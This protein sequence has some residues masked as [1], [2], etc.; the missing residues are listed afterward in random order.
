MGKL[1]DACARELM[2]TAPVIMRT[3]RSEMRHGHDTDL[4]I[5]QFRTLGFIQRQPEASLTDLADHLGIT[6]PSVSKLVDGLVKQELISRQQGRSDRRK[7]T[8]ELTP[9]GTSI[10]NS[11]QA[12][13]HAN[14][15]RTLSGLSSE[16]LKIIHQAMEVLHGLF[17][18]Q[19]KRGPRK[20]S[21]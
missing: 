17:T 1:I 19:S 16:K 3:I 10:I 14:L 12:H 6:P 5:P 15:A 2:E 11:A 13:A 18:P 7:L 4:S 21:K 8:L 9:N 20:N